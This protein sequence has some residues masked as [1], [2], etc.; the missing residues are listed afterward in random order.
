MRKVK[1]DELARVGTKEHMLL[2]LTAESI[3][4]NKAE[5]CLE[6]FQ[7]YLTEHA[8][9]AECFGEDTIDNIIRKFTGDDELLDF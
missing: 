7:S 2:S 1:I 5:T 9:E 6:D 8:D 3:G 4:E